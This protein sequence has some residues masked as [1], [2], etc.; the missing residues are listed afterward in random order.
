MKV[1]TVSQTKS[2]IVL[3]PLA[4]RTGIIVQH[5]VQFIS[6]SMFSNQEVDF[7]E[8]QRWSV[9]SSKLPHQLPEVHLSSSLRMVGGLWLSSTIR[10]S[11][12]YNFELIIR[13]I[14]TSASASIR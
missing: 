5:F 2:R 12:V 13:Y 10:I 14:S 7:V 4:L 11:T 9:L 6:L 1:S 8:E 3:R